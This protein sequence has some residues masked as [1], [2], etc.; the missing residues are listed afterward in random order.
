MEHFLS[1]N[2]YRNRNSASPIEG[3]E[4]KWANFG[5][6]PVCS[7]KIINLNVAFLWRGGVL[8]ISTV[9]EIV[10]VSKNINY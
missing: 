6:L 9:V 1:L 7:A 3:R 5:S 10:G 2:A 8:R 4:E